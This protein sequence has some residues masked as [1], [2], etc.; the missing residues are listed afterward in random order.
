MKR[1]ISLLVLAVYSIVLAHSFVPHHHHS[2]FIQ[3]TQVCDLEE[4]HEHSI[5]GA[6]NCCVDHSNEH[7]SHSFCNFN[8]KTI[9][10]KSVSLSDLFIPSIEIEFVGIEKNNQSVS[11]CYL[12]IQISAPHCR[13]VQLRGPPIFS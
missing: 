8:E 3:N 1:F 4:Q 9:L 13:D 6:A 2:E 5:H 12:P 7:T 10:A 11:D